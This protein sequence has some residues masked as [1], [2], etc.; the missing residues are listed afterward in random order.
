MKKK[1]IIEIGDNQIGG[2]QRGAKGIFYLEA[3]AMGQAVEFGVALR[4]TDSS[5]VVVPTD[6]TGA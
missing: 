4:F 2:G 3:H 6:G 1:G 5:R